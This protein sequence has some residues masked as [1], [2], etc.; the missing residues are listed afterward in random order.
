MILKKILK[1]KELNFLINYFAEI[2][3][4]SRVNIVDFLKII[5]I[6]IIL[7]FFL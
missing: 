3:Q 6:N 5:N 2:C 7:V 1:E 4:F